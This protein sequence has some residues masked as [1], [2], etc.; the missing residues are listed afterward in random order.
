[1]R[2]TMKKTQ[3]L[4]NM[5]GC[6]KSKRNLG[7]KSKKRGGCWWK[8]AEVLA[9]AENV[10]LVADVVPNVIADIIAQVSVI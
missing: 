3:K 4:W 9:H 8:S 1:M 7:S 10:A 2:K 6:S 5:K